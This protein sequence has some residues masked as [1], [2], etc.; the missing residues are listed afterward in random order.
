[1]V[2]DALDRVMRATDG[3]TVLGVH[4]TGKDKVTNR[5]SSALESGVDTAYRSEGDALL[6]ALTREKRKDGPREDRHQ[7]RLLPVGDSCVIESHGNDLGTFSRQGTTV[8]AVL[9]DVF[10]TNGASRSELRDAAIAAGLSRTDAYR[11]H[12]NPCR[13]GESEGR[14]YPG[15]ALLLAA[16]GSGGR[17]NVP[18]S[19]ERPKLRAKRT[20]SPPSLG[21]GR[22]DVFRYGRCGEA[23]R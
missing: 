3:G 18:T 19:Q 6:M 11:G 21:V 7:L 9:W 15:A 8:E 20:V 17:V 16:W 2:V 23:A 22:W 4:H 13:Y 14:R 12:E 10:G 5:G 1:M